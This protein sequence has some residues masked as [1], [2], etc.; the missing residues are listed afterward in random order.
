[1]S[2]NMKSGLGKGLSALLASENINIEEFGDNKVVSSVSEVPINQIEANPFQPRTEFEKQALEELAASIQLHGIIQPVTLRKMGYDK[3]QLI[4]GERRTR[5]AILAGLNS[6]PAYVR[7]ANDQDMLEMALIENIQRENLN[8]IEIALSYKRLLEECDLKQ[9][10]LGE[11]VG[12]DRSTVANYMRLLK[13][14]DEIQAAIK[15]NE[16]SM[17]HARSIL[18]LK[19]EQD[20]LAL[21]QRITQDNLSVRATEKIVK[22]H[23][24]TRPKKDK[25]LILPQAFSTYSGFLKG[26]LNLKSGKGNKGILTIKFND[27]KELKQILDKLS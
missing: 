7:I 15:N 21:F 18:G 3:Y 22:E 24:S 11:R 5:A 10:E 9:D 13:L 20:Q 12:K 6:I 27:E 4:S 16:L 14:P 1:M 25:K 23:G 26:K 2:K 19:D 8:A 17:G